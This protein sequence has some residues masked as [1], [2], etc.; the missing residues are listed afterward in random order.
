MAALLDHERL[1]KEMKERELN[2]ETLAEQLDISD[3]HVRNLCSKD[4]NVSSSLL[5]KLSKL[6]SMPMDELLTVRKE[7]E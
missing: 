3:R 1:C 4:V 5:Y 2:Q 6:F 7:R